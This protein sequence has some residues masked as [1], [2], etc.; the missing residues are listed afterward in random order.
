MRPLAAPSSGSA[1][2]SDG[3]FINRLRLRRQHVP[4]NE[5]TYPPLL[6][7]DAGRSIH[8][9]EAKFLDD[10]IILVEHLS[11]EEAEAFDRVCTP[12]E[13]HTGLVELQLH[14]TCHQT[15]ERHV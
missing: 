7:G 3:L 14:A 13:V 9:L 15:V 10:P 6:F 8:H 12:A 2:I 1:G 5:V 11:L 4:R